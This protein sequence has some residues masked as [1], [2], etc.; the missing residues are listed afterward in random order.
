MSA[1]NAGDRCALSFEWNASTAPHLPIEENFF[2]LGNQK[3]D[4]LHKWAVTCHAQ[5]I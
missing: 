3:Q 2:T 5:E 4:N 1:I